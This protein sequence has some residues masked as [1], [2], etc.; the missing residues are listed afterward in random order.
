[1]MCFKDM[2]FCTAS[3]EWSEKPRTCGNKECHRYFTEQDKIDS[4]EWWKYM[5][6]SAPMA[7][8][9]ETCGIFDD[10]NKFGYGID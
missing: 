5:K 9:T 7:D 8:F 1:M 2:T 10:L 4:E 3:M 6:G